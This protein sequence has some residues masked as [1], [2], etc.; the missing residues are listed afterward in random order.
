MKSKDRE[1]MI[2]VVVR[3]LG[4]SKTE[5]VDEALVK[6][7]C[8]DSLDSIELMMDLE[9]EFGLDLP[10]Y[11]TAKFVTVGDIFDFIGNELDMSG[12]VDK[13]LKLPKLEQA[14]FLASLTGK[15]VDSYEDERGND[16]MI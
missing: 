1:R 15:M 8:N 10:E 11:D 16:V 12:F 2:N 6:D 5:V 3:S 13:I 9:E 7:L 14:K 4:V